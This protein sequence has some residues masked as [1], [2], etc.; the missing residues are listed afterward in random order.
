MSQSGHRPQLRL[1]SA[2]TVAV[3]LLFTGA[4]DGF[5]QSEPDYR[6]GVP[7][8]EQVESNFCVPASILMWRLY[9]GLSPVSQYTIFN[10]IGGAPCDGLDAARGVTIYTSSGYDAYYDLVYG[11]TETERDQMISRRSLRSTARSP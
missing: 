9:D 3:A 10:T 7:Y 4:C 1:L 2:A 6:L 8:R 11:P 5:L